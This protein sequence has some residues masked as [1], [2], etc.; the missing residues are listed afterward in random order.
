AFILEI[1]LGALLLLVFVATLGIRGAERR[2]I[3]WIATWGVLVL[4]FTSFLVRPAPPA[5]GGMFVQD[6]LAIFAKRLFLAATFIGL[7]ASL[8][9]VQPAFVRRAGENPLLTPSALLGMF[10]FA[11]SSARLLFFFPLAATS[12]PLVVLAGS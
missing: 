12:M 1:G 10:G 9:N 6:G 8:S 4:A 3:G 2:V 11:S 5:L 7:L